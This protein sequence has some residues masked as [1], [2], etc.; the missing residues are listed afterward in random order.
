M[1]LYTF[2]NIETNEEF[3][4]LMPHSKVEEF[5]KENTHVRRKVTSSSISYND[6]KK[7]D[8]SFRDILRDIKR[9]SPRSNINTF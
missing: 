1:P 4:E 3:E 6:A 8:D 7:P 2:V 9:N 5:L